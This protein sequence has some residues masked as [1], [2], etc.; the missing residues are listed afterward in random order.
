MGHVVFSTCPLYIRSCRCFL[1]SPDLIAEKTSF[2]AGCG[3]E[4]NDEARVSWGLVEAVDRQ[5][6]KS[7]T[8]GEHET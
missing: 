8:R 5:Q 1:V 3:A 7:R 2:L 4:G 6:K